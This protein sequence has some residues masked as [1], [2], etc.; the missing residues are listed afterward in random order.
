MYIYILFISIFAF[1]HSEW[2]GIWNGREIAPN[3]P[4]ARTVALLEF[5]D[6]VYCSATFL[7]RTTLLTAA[8]CLRHRNAT[9]VSVKMRGNENQWV[10][11]PAF[12]LET[13]PDFSYVQKPNRQVILKNDLALVHLA[14]PFEIEVTPAQI[15]S[16]KWEL[17]QAP[18]EVTD[19]GFGW[20]SRTLKLKILR[21]GKMKAH[22]ERL[23]LLGN[24]VGLRE[25]MSSARQIACPGDSGGPVFLGEASSLEIIAVHSFSDGCLPGSLDRQYSELVEPSFDWIRSRVRSF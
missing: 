2:E 12:Q 18:F 9:E 7:S 23:E 22:I 1:A 16:R 4:L 11:K 6:G 14:E 10:V 17:G 15:S 19:A 24:R 13:H 20:G 3:H 25:E 5:E 21:T 8:H